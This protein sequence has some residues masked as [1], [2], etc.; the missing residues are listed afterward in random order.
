MG[1]WNL[2]KLRW[3]GMS[4]LGTRPTFNGQGFQVCLWAHIG[5]IASTKLIVPLPSV[6]SVQRLPVDQRCVF[7]SSRSLTTRDE[8]VEEDN[9]CSTGR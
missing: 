7:H 8:C 2:S 1:R 9:F 4:P 5:L 3:S 6:L